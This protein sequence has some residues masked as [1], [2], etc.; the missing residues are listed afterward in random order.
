MSFLMV[1]ET[2]MLR[3]IR[4][5]KKRILYNEN[6]NFLQKKFINLQSKYF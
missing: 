5:K 4:K 1:L 2:I 3:K 6:T